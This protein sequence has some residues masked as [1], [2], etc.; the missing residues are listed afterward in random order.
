[1]AQTKSKSKS[2]SK[3]PKG[4]TKSKSAKSRSTSKP[5]RSSKSKGSNGSRSQSSNGSALHGIE[6]GAKAAAGKAKV[7]LIAAGGAALVGAAGG[8]AYRAT[9]SSSKVLGMKMPQGKRVKIRSKDLA[10]AAKQVGDF[11]EQVGELTSELQR[12]RKGMSKA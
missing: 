6:N 9:K 10:K 8:A 12:I 2:K 11:G 5:K 7:P 1:M 3:Q 4:S